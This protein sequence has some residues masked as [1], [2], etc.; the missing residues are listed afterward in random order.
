MHW[1]RSLTNTAH[2]SRQKVCRFF[3]RQKFVLLFFAN[4]SHERQILRRN[5][6]DIVKISES[7]NIRSQN[8]RITTY[9]NHN[10]FDANFFLLLQTYEQNGKHQQKR[11]I[12]VKKFASDMLRSDML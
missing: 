1:R 7:Q 11:K 6:G 4:V 10:I 12:A 3:A 8:I 2:K 9:P 5:S